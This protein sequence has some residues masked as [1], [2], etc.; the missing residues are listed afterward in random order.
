MIDCAS[1]YYKLDLYSY[2]EYKEVKPPWRI[3]NFV[4]PRVNR[5]YTK[6]IIHNCVG[7]YESRC[8][9]AGIV[10][11][12]SYIAAPLIGFG[13]CANEAEHSSP[14]LQSIVAF[15]RAES[16]TANLTQTNLI[17]VSSFCG[18]NGLLW[19]YDLARQP[20]RPHASLVD[21][22]TDVYDLTP[23]CDATQA[24]LG[25]VEKPRFPIAPGEHL[26]CAYKSHTVRGPCRLYGAMAVA[27]AAERNRHA[28]LFMED[29]GVLSH[30]RGEDTQIQESKM[31][32]HL[33]HSVEQVGEN[34]RVEYS[35][36]FVGLR[37]RWVPE[38]HVGCVLTA[39]PYLHL[40]Q[41]AVP[42][43]PEALLDMTLDEWQ[44]AHGS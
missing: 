36:V 27:I 14:M 21:S 2:L 22:V 35:K 17:R 7:P 42:Q 38:G 19:G 23:L 9:S 34:L 26:I 1:S 43:Q 13:L 25:T 31:L 4:E 15:D 28:D 8:A 20:L 5:R 40:A 37:S 32:R 24:L 29:H 16:S 12:G 3:V 44:A 30:E 18:V 11:G 33:L 39:A 10:P 6:R 41:R